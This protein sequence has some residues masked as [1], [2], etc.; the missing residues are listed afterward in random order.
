MEKLRVLLVED[1]AIAARAAAVMLKRVG[2]EVTG[3]VDSGEEAIE[4]AARQSP[5]LVLMDIRLRGGMDGIEAGAVIRECYCIPVIYVSAYLA[6][7]LKNR[8]AGLADA[9]YLAKP[10]DEESLASVVAKVAAGL[11]KVLK[12]EGPN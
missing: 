9:E 4:S 5:E 7:E 12:G 3:I 11:G 1:E 6:E 8:R 10:I 2:C